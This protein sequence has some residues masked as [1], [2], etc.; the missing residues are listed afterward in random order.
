M[1]ASGLERS[2]ERLRVASHCALQ[3]LRR[4][5]GGGWWGDSVQVGRRARGG[6]RF[7]SHFGGSFCVFFFVFVFVLL[8]DLVLALALALVL[9]LLEVF[10]LGFVLAIEEEALGLAFFWVVRVLFS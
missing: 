3:G 4:K 1:M 8:F 9:A 6:E 5:E 7:V 10:T 2:G